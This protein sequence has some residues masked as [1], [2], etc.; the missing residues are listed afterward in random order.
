[1]HRALVRH[2]PDRA[3]LSQ[4]SIEAFIV[5]DTDFI[6]EIHSVRCDV[7]F[8]PVDGHYT[9]NADEAALAAEAC[10]AAVVVPIRWGEGASAEEASRLAARDDLNVHLLVRS[11]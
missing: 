2:T 11:G 10:D 8:L 4:W 1:M 9:M 3:H 7:A 5:G 6:D